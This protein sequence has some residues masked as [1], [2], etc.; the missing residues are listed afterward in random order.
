MR[1]RVSVGS[2]ARKVPEFLEDDLVG[3]GDDQLAGVEELGQGLE[4]CECE[5]GQQTS[6]LEAGVWHGQRVSSSLRLKGVASLKK[7]IKP[8]STFLSLSS[9]LEPNCHSDQILT[10]P[11]FPSSSH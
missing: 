4:G 7:S 9:H 5:E 1:N 11:M 10:Y 2:Q 8:R 6:K 3:F